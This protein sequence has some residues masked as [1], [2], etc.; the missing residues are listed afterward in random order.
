MT[1]IN[2]G[3]RSCI[4]VDGALFGTIL[5]SPRTNKFVFVRFRNDAP[6]VQMFTVEAWEK[7]AGSHPEW[8]YKPSYCSVSC[9]LNDDVVTINV[10]HSCVKEWNATYEV[11][12]TVSWANDWLHDFRTGPRM[13]LGKCSHVSNLFDLVV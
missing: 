1:D 6:Q 13:K 7:L 5:F 2:M 9:V 8:E 3:S 4:F 10:V 12:F 11:P